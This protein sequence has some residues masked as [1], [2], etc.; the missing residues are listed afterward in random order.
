MNDLANLTGQPQKLAVDGRTYLIRP[1]TLDDFGALQQWVNE[2]FPDPMAIAQASLN[3]LSVEAQKF[4]IKEAFAAASRPKPKLGTPEAD[5]LTNS[6]D[7]LREML[8]LMIRRD[9]PSFT[10][11]AAVALY[12][13]IT[14]ADINTVFRV[15]YGLPPGDFGPKAGGRAKED[16]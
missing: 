8:F 4:L 10:R 15:A 16:N 1:L 3:G 13:K 12:G 11:E 5:A 2:Q 7:G 6:L 14:P 9:D